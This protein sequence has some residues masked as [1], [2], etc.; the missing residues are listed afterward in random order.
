MKK[1]ISI[2]ISGILFHIEEDGYASLKKYLEAINRHFSHYDDNQEIISDI[3]N[4]IAEIFLSNLKNNKQVITAENVER[5]IEKMGTIADFQ[6]VEDEP[7]SEA[8]AKMEEEPIEHEYY[9]YITPPE[10]EGATGYK[11][12][13]RL[14]SRKILGGVCAGLAHYLAI[15][16]LWTRLIAI[17]L[18][19]SGRLS[20]R[21]FDILP[22]DWDWSVSLGWWAV[23]AYIVL[24]IILPV[25]FEEPEDKKI[26]KLYRNPDDRVIGGICSGLAAYFSIE[27]LWARLAFIGLVFA[28]GAGLVIYLILWIITPLAKSITERI[29]M[30]GGE[31]TLSN[32]E[33]TIIENRQLPAIPM[34]QP[35][36]K[37]WLAPFRFLGNVLNGIGMALGP[38]GRFI[39]D[40]IRV[41]FGLII[42]SIGTLLTIAPVMLLGVYFGLINN[43]NIGFILNNLP[44][45]MMTELIPMWLA[46]AISVA[47][48]IP[49]L[50]LILLGIS[51]MIRRSLIESRFGLVTLGIW[52]LSIMICAFQI[53]N[54]IANFTSRGEYTATQTLNPKG[55]IL[56]LRA[57]ERE[58]G[59]EELDLVSLT[60]RG[61]E[62]SLI[63]LSQHFE[64]KG[65]S[66]K[67]A[68]NNASS[69]GYEF[70]LQDSVAIF[71][72]TLSF[73]SMAKFRGQSVEQTMMIPYNKPFILEKSMISILKSTIYKNG[74]KL[75]DINSENTWVFNK[76]G[77]LCISCTSEHKSSEEDSL[78]RAKFRELLPSVGSQE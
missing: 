35:R 29:K 26:K 70:E 46:V 69:V 10:Q 40:I 64:S 17:L 38:F 48:F 21:N 1:T 34:Q 15:D 12:L 43:N 9:K 45:G 53:P 41:G 39:L 33:N 52:L 4:R 77:L 73:G 60:L 36:R 22:W 54:T 67:E 61:T 50:V 42:F 30:K 13:T 25:S 56:I 3:E 55:S 18:L 58:T 31:I 65:S 78:S 71:P 76:N 32:I 5:L 68:N 24:W 27:V 44:E 28:G 20:F 75:K 59:L 37:A 47:I 8:K 14:E 51:V 11:K 57:S 49:G 66:R 23:L 7:S 72:R 19:F 62:D 2:N 63:T 16:P 74:Y 6:A